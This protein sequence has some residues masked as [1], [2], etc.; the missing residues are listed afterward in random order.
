MR[1]DPLRILLASD[2]SVGAPFGYAHE[3]VVGR[4]DGEPIQLEELEQHLRTRALVAVDED[5]AAHDG[6]GDAGGLFFER[7]VEVHPED[8]A[9]DRIKDEL[10]RARITDARP[11]AAVA[12]DEPGVQELDVLE[13][14]VARWRELPESSVDVIKPLD[15]AI[16][17]GGNL[18][19]VGLEEGVGWNRHDVT[20]PCDSNH[21][22]RRVRRSPRGSAGELNPVDIRAVARR[23]EEVHVRT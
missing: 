7:G 1:A 5:M 2:R 20:N 15:M 23:C 18:F 4:G 11:R 8:I 22:A 13:G 3:F 16:E 10:E 17:Q 6:V 12:G 9:F 14:E 21:A 19:R